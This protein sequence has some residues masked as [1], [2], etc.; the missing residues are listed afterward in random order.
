MSLYL[1]CIPR[2]GSSNILFLRFWASAPPLL[3]ALKSFHHFWQLFYFENK[4]LRCTQAVSQMSA[5][6]KPHDR[7]PPHIGICLLLLPLQLCRRIFTYGKNHCL[8][9]FLWKQPHSLFIIGAP[10]GGLISALHRVTAKP[11][12]LIKCVLGSHLMAF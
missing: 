3:T 9:P 12:K 11:V 8:S 2:N 7:V 6:E 5:K 10:A 4:T 1:Q